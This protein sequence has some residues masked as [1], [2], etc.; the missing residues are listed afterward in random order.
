MSSA[1]AATY[2][3]VL[4]AIEGNVGI[5][6]LNRPDKLNSLNSA[7]LREI[8]AAMEAFGADPT[9]RAVLITGAGRAFC[10]GADL[11]AGTESTNRYGNLYENFMPTCSELRRF[12]KPVVCAVN[13]PCAGAGVSI[14][15]SCDIVVAAE[16]AYFM[17]AFVNVGLVPDAGSSWIIP[18]LVGSARFTAMAMLAKKIPGR[19]AVEWGLIWECVEDAK[20][21]DAAMDLARQLAAGPP[22]TLSLIKDLARQS[23]KNGYEEQM[24]LEVQFQRVCAHTEDSREARRAFVEKRKPVF[25]GA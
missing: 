4:T 5:L 15:L 12:A 17:Q 25:R 14:A 16:S 19:Q 24:A 13:G 3:T 18:R 2:Q 21:M 22:K 20:L 7:L 10:A 6:T 9:V 1:P 23:A 8:G 11:T